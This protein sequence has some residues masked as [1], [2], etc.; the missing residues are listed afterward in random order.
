M[1]T[2]KYFLFV[3]LFT[4]ELSLPG[5]AGARE[6]KI[7]AFELRG[8]MQLQDEWRFSIRNKASKSSFWLEIGASA[9]GLTALSFDADRGVLTLDHQGSRHQL[10]MA[11]AN[12]SPIQVVRSSTSSVI[13]GDTRKDI[14]P[15]PTKTPPAPPNGGLP[16]KVPPPSSAPESP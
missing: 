5:I 9:H 11:E 3:C 1:R 13:L 6:Y 4:A 16:P 14:P 2:V 10:K 12:A 7:G 15:V 8:A